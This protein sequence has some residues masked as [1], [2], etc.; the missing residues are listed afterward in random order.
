MQ[1]CDLLPLVP[2]H[3]A[4]VLDAMFFAT[5]TGWATLPHLP[6]GPPGAEP[7]LTLSLFFTGDICGRF[8]VSLEQ[9]T[10]GSLAA[11]F[12]GEEPA[13]VSPHDAAEVV[14]ELANMLCGSVMSRI[15]GEHKFVL[16]HPGPLA[17]QPPLSAGD[18]LVCV[19]ETDVGAIAVWIALEAHPCPF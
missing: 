1:A 12:L 16:S 7:C 6:I 9:S 13:A 15:E 8:A 3:C 18:A 17:A 10:A 4:E 14:A 19:L 5:V 11:N 2:E